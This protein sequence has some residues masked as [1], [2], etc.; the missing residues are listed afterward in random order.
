MFN[1]Y[2]R[3]TFNLVVPEVT[4]PIPKDVKHRE[5]DL[6]CKMINKAQSFYPHFWILANVVSL[7]W[8]FLLNKNPHAMLACYMSGTTP[9]ALQIYPIYAKTTFYMMLKLPFYLKDSYNSKSSLQPLCRVKN[10]TGS[11]LALMVLVLIDIRIP[12]LA[13]FTYS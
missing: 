7:L 8:Y 6:N 11:K 10:K 2:C 4:L 12:S 3:R 9:C 1:C 13:T 5:D